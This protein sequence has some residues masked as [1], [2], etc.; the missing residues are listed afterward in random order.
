MPD[1]ELP[2]SSEPP[3]DATVRLKAGDPEDPRRTQQLDPALVALVANSLKISRKETDPGRTQKL[4][5]SSQPLRRIK[6]DAPA[7]AEGHAESP[8]THS[9]VARGGGSKTPWLL[10]SLVVVAGVAA[11]LIFPHKQAP[12]P[13]PVVAN[14]A[15]PEPIP[16]AA[17][18]YLEQ[19]QAG[20]AHAMRMLGVMYYY[21]L[22]VP[23][24]RAKGLLWYRKAADK[25]S[26]A[27]RE[28]L[29]K[30]ESGS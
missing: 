19:A 25:G 27:A 13:R 22:N 29:R 23:Q 1:P 28:E 3:P 18:L 11:Y 26:D 2:P 9:E 10:G 30:L 21:G 20:D 5:L 7:G 16:E 12:S 8:F 14:E 15:Q 17:T 24:D 6:E 4:R